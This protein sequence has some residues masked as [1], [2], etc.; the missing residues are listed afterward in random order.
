MRTPSLRPPTRGHLLALVAAAVLAAPAAHALDLVQAWQGAQQHAPDAAAARAAREAGAARAEQARALWRPS[1]VAEAGAGVTQHE[2]A[3]RGARFAAP[4]FGS[5]GDV[6]FDTS[7]TGG[8]ATRWALALRQP[9]YSRERSARAD[10]LAIAAE[11]AEHAWVDARQSLMLATTEAYFLAAL[12]DQR[13]HLLQRQQQAVDEAAAQARDRFRL[14]DRP[15]TDVHEASARAASLQA[16][17]LAAETQAALARQALADVTGLPQAASASEPLALPGPPRPAELAPLSDWLARAQGHNA[18]LQQAEARL[19]TAQAQAR[20]SGAAFSPT[21]DAVAQL[22]HDRMAGDGDYASSASQTARQA[23][24]GV[25]LTVP[26][27]TGGLRSAQH[28]EARAA[29][30]EARAGLERARQQVAQQTRSAWLDLA[31]GERQTAALEAALQ[32]SRARLD[33]TRVG[34]EVGDRTTLDLL[35]AENDA[36]AAELALLQARVHLLAGRLRLAALAG[37]L[38]DTQLQLANGQLVP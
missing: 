21:L 2:T 30:D 5:S 13:V 6:S 25:Q 12:A 4:A 18:G 28:A 24:I 23:A 34:R 16:E 3:V 9:L 38:D 8:T 19:R 17:R 33:A 14:G 35:Q 26:L 32:A 10:A 29:V 1:V 27:Y 20:A 36:A 7:V 31:V 11:A 37:E 15:V 22:S